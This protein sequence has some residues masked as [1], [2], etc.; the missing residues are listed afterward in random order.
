[1]R[2]DRAAGGGGGGAD[3]AAVAG[4][5]QDVVDEVRSDVHQA[6]ASIVALVA[7]DDV[8]QPPHPPLLQRRSAR[9]HRRPCAVL[10]VHRRQHA[11]LP[12]L[13]EDLVGLVERGADG[14][15]DFQV[16]AG[17]LQHPQAQ[18]VVELRGTLEGCSAA[19]VRSV[20]IAFQKVFEPFSSV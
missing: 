14:L 10:V 13:R 3:R 15:L 4:E 5:V 1:M 18:R 11:V 20:S 8:A 17:V 2:R 16:D 7:R 9:A 6:V 19:G 12:R